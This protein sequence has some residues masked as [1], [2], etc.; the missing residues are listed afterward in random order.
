[1]TLTTAERTELLRVAREG[2]RHFFEH[3][4]LRR[5]TDTT[6]GDGLPLSLHAKRAAFV[7]LRRADD[8]LR[9]CVGAFR[10]D[11]PLWRLV[12]E[13]AVAAARND[14]RYKSVEA[15]ELAGL[16]IEVSLPGPRTPIRAPVGIELGRHGLWLERG[17]RR[18]VLLPHVATE[19]GLDVPGF[20]EAICLRADLPRG[21]WRD[22]KTTLCV[23]EAETFSE[24]R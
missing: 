23:F 14:A 19:Q 22:A 9:G 11:T 1:M 10:E 21:A 5:H 17:M 13:L 12:A 6:P 16:F 4:A 2:M 24:P 8:D 15:A 20:L 18:C 7:S 3:G